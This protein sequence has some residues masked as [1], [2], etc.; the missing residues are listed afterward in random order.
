ML[1]TNSFLHS[2]QTFDEDIMSLSKSSTFT[3]TGLLE[4]LNVTRDN[5][6]YLWYMTR[7]VSS[8]VQ[9]FMVKNC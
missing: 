4:Q 5:S 8:V 7:C 1:P 9:T 3:V 2:W 6:D